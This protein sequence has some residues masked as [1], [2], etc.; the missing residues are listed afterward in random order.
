MSNWKIVKNGVRRS[1]DE[2]EE[3]SDHY[4]MSGGGVDVILEW[5]VSAGSR[6][7]TALRTRFPHLRT[8]PDNTHA[9]LEHVLIT[10]DFPPVKVNGKVEVGKLESVELGGCFL[11]VIRYPGFVEERRIFPAREGKATVFDYRRITNTTNAPIRIDLPMVLN[12]INA[13]CNHTLFVATQRV[14]TRATLAPGESC[15]YAVNF[16]DKLG[17]G[18]PELELQRRLAFAGN[19]FDSLVLTTPDR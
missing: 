19:C 15:R 13:A 10:S 6:L 5:E 9:S 3:Y 7:A 14:D 1:F 17:S 4:A 16:S 2:N 11:A 8:Q 18:N 12:K